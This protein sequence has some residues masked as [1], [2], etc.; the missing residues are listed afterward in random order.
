MR[1]GAAVKTAIA[2]AAVHFGRIDH[3]VANA[4]IAS[5]GTVRQIE[6]AAEMGLEHNLGLTCDPVAGMDGRR[7][8]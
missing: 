4:G 7:R 6:Y 1:D 3:V 2:A 5:Y 8:P